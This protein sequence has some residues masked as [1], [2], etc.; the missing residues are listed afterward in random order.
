MPP[1]PKNIIASEKIK[2][3]TVVNIAPK[4]VTGSPFL[5]FQMD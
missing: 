3:A 2:N 4:I 5:P 1:K